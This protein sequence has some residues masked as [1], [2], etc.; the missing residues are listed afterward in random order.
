[1]CNSVCF[2][3]HQYTTPRELADM[4]G[5]QDELVWLGK[6]PFRR[7]SGERHWRDLDLCLCAIDLEATL[8]KAGLRWRRGRDP[9]EYLVSRHD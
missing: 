6:N 9:M 1:M 2:E 7:I 3:G 5:G 8:D 4:L